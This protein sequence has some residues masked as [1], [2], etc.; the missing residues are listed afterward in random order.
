MKSLKEISAR[1]KIAKGKVNN[2]S[3]KNKKTNSSNLGSAFKISTEF[4]AAVVVGSIIG[5]ILDNLFGTKPWLII[6]FFIIGVIAGM[7][8]VIRSAKLMQRNNK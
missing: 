7:L 6:I 8:N 4:V 1:L 3:I 2:S 5:F